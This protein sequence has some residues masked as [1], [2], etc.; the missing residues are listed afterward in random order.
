MT[1]EIRDLLTHA[2]KSFD[3]IHVEW[4]AE[5][6]TALLR[7]AFERSIP[8]LPH[9]LKSGSVVMAEL[10]RSGAGS[11]DSDQ[12]FRHDWRAWWRKPDYW[13]DDIVW[14][15]GATAV[16]IVRGAISTSY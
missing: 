7:H 8:D 16:S 3:T 6:D 9:R 4:T 13:R 1:R 15:G 11:S 12:A 2:S 10:R 14:E 5:Y